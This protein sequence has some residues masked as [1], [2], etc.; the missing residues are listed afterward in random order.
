V[1]S[2]VE[3]ESV[4]ARAKSNGRDDTESHPVDDEESVLPDELN[5]HL[6]LSRDVPE[7]EEGNEEN[8]HQRDRLLVV[9]QTL[10]VQM[11][12]RRCLQH[13]ILYRENRMSPEFDAF[14]FPPQ[15]LLLGGVT[16]T[17]SQRSI[18]RFRR[19]QVAARLAD[20][21]E[22]AGMSQGHFVA[23]SLQL[24]QEKRGLVALIVVRGGNMTR[25]IIKII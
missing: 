18:R 15:S 11:K 21:V 19:L 20:V 7:R 5:I 4:Q 24:K 22:R 6:M 17:R 8:R 25:K 12:Q 23:Q 10:P 3:Q 2:E 14:P 13:A 16:A 1:R 9:Q